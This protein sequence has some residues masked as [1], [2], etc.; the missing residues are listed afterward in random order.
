MNNKLHK[1]L[2]IIWIVSILELANHAH[3]VGVE[4]TGSN[5]TVKIVTV[6]SL[7]SARYQLHAL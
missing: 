2:E 3:T 1:Y 4:Q 7:L 6:S 5:Y